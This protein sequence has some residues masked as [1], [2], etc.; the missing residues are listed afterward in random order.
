MIRTRAIDHINMS[1]SDIEQS[2][3]FYR[4]VFGFE[5]VE[6]YRDAQVDPWA[7]IAIPGAA[8]L[9]LHQSSQ[10]GAPNG[11]TLNH[12]GLV[13]EDLDEA[14]KHL[15]N[16]GVR[17]LYDSGENG[18]LIDWGHSNSIYIQDPDGHDI[19]LTSKFGGGMA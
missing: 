18:P 3:D 17:V 19:E 9:A 5:V 6:D 8:V 13:V 1:V 12:F 14:L 2:V 4:R 15:R 7:I 16:E 11:L 10:R